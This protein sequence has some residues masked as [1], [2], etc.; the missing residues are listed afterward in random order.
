[1][2]YQSI[3]TTCRRIHL[4]GIR[5]Y[6]NNTTEKRTVMKKTFFA[7]GLLLISALC[8]SESAF[9]AGFNGYW[10]EENYP[11]YILWKSLNAG[12]TIGINRTG[13]KKL[14]NQ[15]NGKAFD[16]YFGGIILGVVLGDSWTNANRWM[17]EWTDWKY[18]GRSDLKR[19]KADYGEDRLVIAF[20]GNNFGLGEIP[21]SDEVIK[22]MHDF[23]VQNPDYKDKDLAIMLPLFLP[24]NGKY[25]TFEE[26]KNILPMMEEI[27][28]LLNQP[29]GLEEAMARVQ[30]SQTDTTANATNMQPL[31]T[32][33]ALTPTITKPLNITPI[34]S[35]A[36]SDNKE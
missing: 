10:F 5:I 8:F 13:I 2:G 26:I 18:T 29:N 14:E 3:Q 16:S 28:S 6:S 36:T 4:L 35:T 32:T 25:M 31:S 21:D 15:A 20:G 24:E 1:M 30:K 19:F 17:A 23:Y 12:D 11:D 22:R 27:L 7:M 9:A 34:V 33:T